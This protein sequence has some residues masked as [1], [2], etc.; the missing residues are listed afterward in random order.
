MFLFE[1]DICRNCDLHKGCKSIDIPAIGSDT[2]DV[3]ILNEYP[4]NREDL[5]GKSSLLNKPIYLIVHLLGQLG[6]D[7]S[8][9][10]YYRAVNCKPKEGDE[11]TDTYINICRNKVLIDIKKAKPKVIIACGNSSLKSLFNQSEPGIHGWTGWQIPSHDLNCWI[12]PTYNPQKVIDD[13]I[14]GDEK[15]WDKQT[16]YTDT[17]RVLRE[18]LSIV[19]ELIKLSI[20]KNKSYE[21]KKLIKFNEV[22]DFFDNIVIK[23]NKFT[24]DFETIGTKPYFP[25]SCILSVAI[26]FDENISYTFPVSYYD[27]Y[28]K[29]KYWSDIQ[30]KTILDKLKS[31]LAKDGITKIIHNLI[32]ESEWSLAMFGIQLKDLEDTMLQKYILD[33]RRGT[34]NLD[35]LAFA[36]F[37]VRWKKYPQHIMSNLTQISVDELLEYNGTDTIFEHR[38]Y[39]I[40]SNYLDND[41]K[42]KEQYYEQIRTARSIAKMQF[43]GA[44]TN[45]DSRH[46]LLKI[47]TAKK[48]EIENDIAL[49]DCIK[50]FTSIHGRKPL[51]NSNSKDIPII[52]FDIEHQLSFKKTKRGNISIDK[53]VLNKF[54]ERGSL[55]CD[56]LL[57]Y[58]E[59]SGAESKMLKSYTECVY[60]DGKYHTNFY[61]VETGRLCIAKGTKIQTIC[62]RS[63]HPD[64]INIEDIKVNDFVYTFDDELNLKLK[65]VIWTGQT[66]IKKVIRLHWRGSGSRKQG[67]TDITPEHKVRLASGEYIE[68][69]NLSVMDSVLAMNISI[70]WGNKYNHYITSIEYLDQEV[71]VYDIEVED[72]NNFIANEIC[73]HNSSNNL[74]LQNLDKRKHPEIRQLICAPPGHVLLIADEGQLE[75]RIIAA[76]SNCTN[77]IKAIIDGYD[78]HYGKAIE[79]Y[80]EEVIKNADKKLL[81]LLRFNAKS[82]FVFP[83]FY[84]STPKSTANRLGISIEHAQ[85]LYDKLFN[86][87]PEIKIWQNEVLKIY[88]KKRYV[89][90]PPGRR[91]YAPLTTNKILNTPVQGCIS[92][93]SKIYIKDKGF[94]DIKD[95]IREKDIE[96]WDGKKYVKASCAYSGKKQKVKIKFQNGQI[97]E[98]SPD[99]KLLYVNTQGSEI[100][101]T[102][103]EL[104]GKNYKNIRIRLSDKVEQINNKLQLPNYV[105]SRL[106]KRIAPN[107]N[108]FNF[109]SL[110]DFNL[111]VILGRLIT[112]GSIEYKKGKGQLSWIIAEHE[113]NI[114]NYLIEQISLISKPSIYE[115]IRKNRNQKIWKIN[116]FCF[117]LVHRIKYLRKEIPTWIWGNK[118]CLRGFLQGIFDGDGTINKDNIVLCF[119]K[120]FPKLSEK[121]AH[122]IQ[123]ALLLFGIQS[124]L[125]KMKERTN[126]SIRKKDCK[127][128]IT[129][130][131]FLN[132]TKQQKIQNIEIKK[133]TEV[134]RRTETIESIDI[135]DEYID[136]YDIINSES[137][138]FMANNFIVHNSSS[139]IVCRAMN[140]LVERGYWVYL[141]CHDEIVICVKEED[142]KYAYEEMSEIMTVKEFDFMLNVPLEISSTI[143]LDWYNT[144][145]TKEIFGY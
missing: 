50:T 131:G 18:N 6:I 85:Q 28:T 14:P 23:Y 30:E 53:E 112:D 128:F 100:W 116:I 51:L 3:Y 26:S 142:A 81:K 43:D 16:N 44:C 25:D 117:E 9:I 66:G 15:Y 99:H 144:I 104:Q 27:H 76:L 79:I 20:P 57:Q 136:M 82:S 54:S 90:I 49:L 19:P 29:I 40:Q 130:I 86:E 93:E 47:F 32:F 34:M 83:T 12:V 45:S 102:A 4:S 59:Y 141:N 88:N 84:G 68:A 60:P 56:L 120:N 36:T 1:E 70:K 17:L 113:K 42:L 10:R 109:E 114:L 35:F 75:A 134:I 121:M 8:R 91:R 80:G 31:L 127:T 107:K 139:S 46:N 21:I 92:G 108:Y 11:P 140:K 97:F 37:G 110:S 118:E 87:Y 78:I 94:I 126:L 103:R 123:H 129:E 2:P 39:N 24:I 111:G 72:T 145:E 119:G 133:I 64:G 65:K 52:L 38:L 69:K 7:Q 96:I 63:V 124:R 132:N 105:E 143:G 48:E 73:V 98:C 58:R 77:L 89:E 135:T 55:F 41:K 22:I 138:R 5:M 33:C 125:N 71:P 95:C 13:G 67:F 115:I 61:F 101:K 122:E 137:G 106:L 62:D 74:N